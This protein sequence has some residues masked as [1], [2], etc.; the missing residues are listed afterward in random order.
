V[1][2]LGGCGCGVGVG[3]SAS[4]AVYLRTLASLMAV[5]SPGQ[6]LLSLTHAAVLCSACRMLLA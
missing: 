2:C 3:V 6:M 1:Y 4:I 5:V